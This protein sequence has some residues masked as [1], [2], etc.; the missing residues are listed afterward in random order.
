MLFPFCRFDVEREEAAS[1]ACADLYRARQQKRLSMDRRIDQWIGCRRMQSVQPSDSPQKRLA[2][3]AYLPAHQ[4][5][6]VRLQQCR[7]AERELLRCRQ[8]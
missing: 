7:V 2:R 3:Q 5:L 6:H 8:A 4:P 1:G